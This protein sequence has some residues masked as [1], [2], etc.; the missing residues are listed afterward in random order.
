MP[1]RNKPAPV[2][3]AGSLPTTPQILREL[4]LDPDT[5][6]VP[7][8]GIDLSQTPGNAWVWEQAEMGRGFIHRMLIR[9][10]TEEEH[11]T[12]AVGLWVRPEKGQE[13][14]LDDDTPPQIIIPMCISC[15]KE[16]FNEMDDS[17]CLLLTTAPRGE[18][19]NLTALRFG[20][21]EIWETMG[22]AVRR[23]GTVNG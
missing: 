4:N 1:E 8:I 16:T 6:A 22:E 15:L 2:A 17:D 20:E 10:I 19:V 5:D 9:E 7:V 18:F 13:L 11:P 12:V 14:V 23:S 21:D 3:W